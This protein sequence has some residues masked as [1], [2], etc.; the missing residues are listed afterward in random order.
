MNLHLPTL[1][2]AQGADNAPGDAAEAEVPMGHRH[3][4]QDREEHMLALPDG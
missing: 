4:R 2:K 1:P 3:G